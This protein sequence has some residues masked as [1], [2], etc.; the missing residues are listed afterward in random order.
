MLGKGWYL[1]VGGGNHATVG[2][3]QTR[4]VR[5]VRSEGTVLFVF[6]T[7]IALLQ[8]VVSLML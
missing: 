8:S 4:L 6:R 3:S 7:S 1:D 2:L 5:G